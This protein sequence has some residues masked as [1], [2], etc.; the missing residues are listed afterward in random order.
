M[1]EFFAENAAVIWFVLLIV[2]GVI[3]AVTVG[4]VSIWFALGALGA[5]IAKILGAGV[6]VQITVF[7]IVSIICITATR[8]LVKKLHSK[9]IQSTNADRCIGQKAVVIEEIDNMNAKGQVKVNGNVWTARS[10]S[11]EIIPVD[12]VVKTVRI[13]G[14]KMIVKNEKE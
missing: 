4:L 9:N 11:N 14:V 12:T 5:L 10:E 2:F 7:I 13:D 8:P 6:V 3:E 1:I